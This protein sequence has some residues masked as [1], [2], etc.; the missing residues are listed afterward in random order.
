MI[1]TTWTIFVNHF[2]DG[3]RISSLALGLCVYIH[4]HKTAETKQQKNHSAV[5][6]M[7]ITV[8]QQE[9][10]CN[11]KAR[12]HADSL[13]R[14]LKLNGIS[15]YMRNDR[16]GFN[17]CHRVFSNTGYSR[18]IKWKL[19]TKQNKYA[20]IT[21]SPPENLLTRRCPNQPDEIHVNVVIASSP[22]LSPV[23]LPLRPS[24][25]AS[26]QRCFRLWTHRSIGRNR[27]VIGAGRPSVRVPVSTAAQR[28]R[29]AACCCCCWRQRHVTCSLG[30]WLGELM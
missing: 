30:G 11:I 25:S 4:I 13:V 3:N 7:S 22:E 29:H 23:S 20:P 9:I 17:F 28:R 8:C 12:F 10:F 24:L 15:K 27:A 26:S 6:I 14:C 2:F 16:D 19:N 5:L 1:R 18:I 21:A